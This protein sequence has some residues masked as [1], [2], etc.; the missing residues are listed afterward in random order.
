MRI[1]TKNLTS[2]LRTATACA[3]LWVYLHQ[4]I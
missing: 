4:T 2:K 3:I 1:K